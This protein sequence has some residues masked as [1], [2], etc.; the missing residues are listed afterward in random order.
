MR[1]SRP[2]AFLAATSLAFAPAAAQPSEAATPTPAAEQ[3]EPGTAS[4]LGDQPLGAIHY[5]AFAAILA[6]IAYLIYDRLLSD[7]ED[8]EPLSP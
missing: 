4:T 2:F 3:V 6:G 1:F 7:D 8:D 5:L